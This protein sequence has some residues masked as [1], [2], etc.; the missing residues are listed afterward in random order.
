MISNN[1]HMEHLED[2]VLN[3]GIKGANDALNF[4]EALR[5]SLT[6]SSKDAI[7]ATVKWDGAPAIVVGRTDNKLFVSTKSYFNKTPVMYYSP[8]EIDAADL[9]PDLADKL[10]RALHFLKDLSI[11]P[12]TVIQGDF[13]YTKDD[14]KTQVIDSKTYLIFHPNTIVYAVPKDSELANQILQ[15]EIGIVFHTTVSHDMKPFKMRWVQPLDKVWMI[16]AE[17]QDLSG[18]ATMTKNEA[19]SLKKELD[20]AN[21]SMNRVDTRVIKQIPECKHL[22]SYIKVHHNLHIRQGQDIISPMKY[23]KSL[24]DYLTKRVQKE[25][26]D[27]KTESGQE[28]KK[29]ALA[30]VIAFSKLPLYRVASIFEMQMHLAKA[31]KIIINKLNKASKLSTFLKTNSGFKVTGEEGY[32]AIDRKGNTVKLVDRLEFSYSNFNPEIVKGWTNDNRR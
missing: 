24:Q 1:T 13:L 31:K 19:K 10:K 5:D 26:N 25:V 23:T 15:S 32:V 9:N 30:K 21:D 18:S 6:S 12:N 27:L 14:I 29:L 16:D 22:L 11:G 28:R 2:L 8:K 20:L 17:Y 7:N 3:N 4:L